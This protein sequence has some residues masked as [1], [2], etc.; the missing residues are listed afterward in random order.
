M[1]FRAFGRFYIIIINY[2]NYRRRTNRIL[3][4]RTLRNNVSTICRIGMD[5][6]YLLPI[7]LTSVNSC[8][9]NG[10]IRTRHRV[11]P[12][13]TLL[14]LPPFS[15]LGLSGSDETEPSYT[16]YR[17]D[18]I[19]VPGICV[20]RVKHFLIRPFTGN[21][22]GLFPRFFGDFRVYV[23]GSTE[24]SFV[25]PLVVSYIHLPSPAG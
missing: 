11:T 5:R 4:P 23:L 8:V 18:S 1:P 14:L 17:R 22:M 15:D 2:K 21:L 13:Y 20:Y 12:T 16:A 25:A 9:I 3:T 7:I 10:S 6:Y 19:I 24:L